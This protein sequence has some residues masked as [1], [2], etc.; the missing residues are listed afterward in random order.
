MTVFLVTAHAAS[1]ESVSDLAEHAARNS[2]RDVKVPRQ[3]VHTLESEYRA[4][5]DKNGV[6]E[7]EG[8][9]RKLL[10]MSVDLTQ[11]HPVALHENSRILTPLGGGVVDLCDYVTPLK[12]G[13]NLKINAKKE[14]GSDIS[15]LRMFYV[16]N[17]KTRKVDGNEFGAGC[18]KY[19]EITSFFHRKGKGF[20]LYT[21][22]QRYLSVMA[23]TFVAVVFER[24]A[25]YVG[26]LTFTDSRYP[27]VMCE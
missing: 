27:D 8:L 25:L 3:L 20:D 23:G 26:S 17:G 15:G 13:F 11:K 14:D 18:D 2:S 24:E 4:F 10:N 12:G 7:K 16:S 19:M 21:A 1:E 5:L 9:K 22:G 6:S